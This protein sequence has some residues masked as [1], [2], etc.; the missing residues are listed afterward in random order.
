MKILNK[1]PFAKLTLILLAVAVSAN[2]ETGFDS[3]YQRD[4]NIFY[5]TNKYA[6]D[7]PLNP[8]NRFDSDNPFNPVNRFDPNNPANPVNQSIGTIHSI[9]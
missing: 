4:Y 1:W 9:R 8:A 7:N 3:R 6:S 2:G 5:P